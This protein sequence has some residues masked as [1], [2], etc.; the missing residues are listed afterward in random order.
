VPNGS[1]AHLRAACEAS[2]RRLKSETIDL[3]FLHA[4]DPEVPL[5]ES[6]GVLAALRSEGKVRLVGLSNVTAD[7]LALAASVLPVSAVQNAY[8]VRRRRRFG[9]DPVLAAC[10]RMGI[11][12]MA[13]QPLAVGRLAEDDAVRQVAARHGA[14]PGQVSLAWLLGQ[15]HAIVAIPGTTSVRHLEENVAAVRL[16]LSP[17]DAVLLSIR[18]S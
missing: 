14:T 3:Y 4:P 1:P 6:L 13:S 18:P 7:E 9:P 15:S 10:E 5:G 8:N 17:E 12:Y 2:L 11:A 16:P